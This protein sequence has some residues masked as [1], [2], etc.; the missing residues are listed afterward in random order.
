M[1]K[2]KVVVVDDDSSMH[3]IL[4]ELYENSDIIKIETSYTDPAVFMKDAP[5]LCFDLCLLDIN[6]PGVNGLVL[7]QVLGNKPYI[8]ITGSE[9]RLK[10]AL[11]LKPIDIVTK[12]FNK[13]RLDYALEKAF[14]QIST[15]IVYGLYNVAESDKKVKLHLPDF[16]FVGIDDSDSRHK[17]LT[18]NGGVKYTLMDCRLE[19]LLTDAPQLIQVNRAQLVSIHEIHEVDHDK[20]TIRNAKQ[21]SIPEEI[22]LSP[23]YKP[24]V[25]KRMFYR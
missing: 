3:E 5:T 1:K 10:D 6:M 22:T 4:K 21:N 24:D 19:D 7:A 14:K 11:G 13:E 17:S 23:K 18:M 20:V 15:N 12:P 16:V 8:F 9:D 25:L 2:L